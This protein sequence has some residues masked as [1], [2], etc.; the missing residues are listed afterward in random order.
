MKGLFTFALAGFC[1]A[2]CA[3][4]RN[5][6]RFRAVYQSGSADYDHVGHLVTD[7]SYEGRPDDAPEFESDPSVKSPGGERATCAFDGRYQTKYLGFGAKTWLQVAFAKP[8]EAKSYLVRAAN[9]FDNR[10][11]KD[12]RLLGSA[13]GSSF[14]EL[15]AQKDHR[16]EWRFQE[17]RHEIARPRAFRFYRLAVD[18]NHGDLGDD[19]RTPRIQLSEFDLLGADGAS[20][21]RA[22]DGGPLESRWI[23]AKD[24]GEWLCVDLGEKRKFDRVVL[25]WAMKGEAREYALEASDDRTSWRT[26][27]E[28]SDGRGGREELRFAGTQA[29]YVRL[30]CRKAKNDL[31]SLVELEVWGED[32]AGESRAGRAGWTLRRASE[33]AETGERI[34]SAGFDDSGWLPAVVPG[35]VMASYLRAGAVPDMNIEDNQL[36][37]SDAYFTS[38]FWYRG[39]FAASAPKSGRRLWLAFDAVNWKADVFLNGKALGTVEGAFRRASFDVTRVVRQ[40]ENHV[41]VRIRAPENP[42]VVKVQNFWDPGKNGGALG[43]DAPTIHAS[44]GWDWMPTVRGRNI[45]IYRDVRTDETGDVTMSDGWAVTDLDVERR[46]FSKA[47]V[48]LRTRLSN[49][50]GHACRVVVKASVA[51]GGLAVDSKPFELAPGETREVEVG[52]LDIR[53]PRLWWPATYGG[54]PLYSARLSA[55]VDGA[56]SDSE[57]FKFGVRKFT[58]GEG[59]PLRIYCNGTRIVCRGGNWGMDDANLMCSPDDYDTKVRLHAEANFTMIRNWVGMVN[60]KDFYDA[61]DKYGVLVWDD[62]WLANP[63]DGPDPKDVE[64]F[65]ANARDKVAKV[66]R[67]PSVV[68]YCGRN[69]GDPPH[70]LY[71][72]LP[73]LVGELDGTRHYIPHSANRTVSG[74]GPYAL[75]DPVWYFE[76]GTNTLHSERGQP[77][78]PE[79]ESMRL[80]LGE[81]H[82]WPRDDMWGLHDF[83]E[84]GAQ[85]CRTFVRYL[86]SSY[87]KAE[88]FEDFVRKAQLV[89][90]ENHKAMF[91]STYAAEGNGLLMWMSQS[92]WPSMVWQTYDY[93]HD[94]N[95]GYYGA[96]RANQSLNVIRDPRTGRCLIVNATGTDRDVSVRAEVLDLSGRSL[97]V[98]ARRARLPAD[99]TVPWFDVPHLPG[100]GSVRLLR[101][102]VREASGNAWTNF[103]WYNQDGGFDYR[104]LSA[105]AKA[106]VSVKAE[107]GRVRLENEGDAPALM[108]RVKLADARGGRVLP[109]HWSDNY[110]S[111]MPGESVSLAWDSPHADKAKKALVGGWNVVPAEA[112]VQ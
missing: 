62:F 19:G 81:R 106:K 6:A 20:L 107:R 112:A 38:D 111:L 100:E 110:V 66:R 58:Y 17:K 69:E 21:L 44:N 97:L 47:K 74:F 2:A 1:C 32:G 50:S 108:V 59:T 76:H 55:E 3:A 85:E 24:E 10:D 30:D 40:G 87:G 80:M 90:Y 11:P 101:T 39:T 12:F 77:N 71:K 61:C 22:A 25:T 8:V 23:S 109:V 51:P 86:E 92:A 91:E 26:L 45:G 7:G 94:V 104:E 60:S 70:R 84:Y 73:E 5:I 52:V 102:T 83:T 31:F 57:E 34:S 54:Q 88:G 41:A 16:F 53:N 96:R 79:V 36:M 98:E 4:P 89:A 56:V 49:A 65:L 105:L 99:S 67:H 63:S 64:M 37:L 78:V 18:S 27:R 43:F 33:V 15:D 75:K 103:G 68:L 35:T 9:D 82:L 46:D 48:S 93:W 28:V 95:G 42:D 14:V 29:R 72:A 13:D